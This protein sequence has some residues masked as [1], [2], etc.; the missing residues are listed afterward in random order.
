MHRRV[1]LRNLPV[2]L[3]PVTAEIFDR[4]HNTVQVITYKQSKD[5][6][7]SP[8]GSVVTEKNGRKN[9]HFE[10]FLTKNPTFSPVG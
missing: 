10:A 5:T 2:T 8:I 6:R 3:E 1:G 9:F 7:I 4:F